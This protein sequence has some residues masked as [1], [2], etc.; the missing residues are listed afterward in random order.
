MFSMWQCYG[1]VVSLR[2]CVYTCSKCGIEIDRDINATNN[3]SRRGLSRQ[4]GGDLAERFGSV[5][6]GVIPLE[7]RNM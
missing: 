6:T 3:I 2:E 1:E 7:S 5:V 4:S